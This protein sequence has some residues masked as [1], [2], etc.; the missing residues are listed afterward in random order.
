MKK[1]IFCDIDNTIADQYGYFLIQKKKDRSFIINNID[2]YKLK[3]IPYSKS[4]I[5]KLT[6]LYQFHWLSARDQRDYNLTKMWLKKNGFPCKN[7]NLVKRHK[8]KLKFLKKIKTETYIYIDELKY[9]Y[10]N[11]K[12]KVMTKLIKEIKKE[13]INFIRFKNNWREITKELIF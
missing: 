3:K 7:I 1:K 9:D 12:P 8:D 11:K 4:S 5:S 10:E 6:K 2:L 13:K